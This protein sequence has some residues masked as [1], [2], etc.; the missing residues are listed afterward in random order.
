MWTDYCW[1][2][3]IRLVMSIETCSTSVSLTLNWLQICVV[4]TIKMTFKCQFEIHKSYMTWTVPYK[5]RMESA[6]MVTGIDVPSSC[7]CAMIWFSL[8]FIPT[9]WSMWQESL[10]IYLRIRKLR[11]Q[12]A[13]CVSVPNWSLITVILLPVIS[14]LIHHCR[15]QQTGRRLDSIY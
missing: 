10:V 7:A 2:H 4:L 14:R 6:L 5:W 12:S 8:N 9:R 13:L 1:K 3:D 15:L 11:S